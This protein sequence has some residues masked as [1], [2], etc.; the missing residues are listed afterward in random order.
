MKLGCLI[1]LS[2]VVLLTGC[3]ESNQSKTAKYISK[4]PA[5][6]TDILKSLPDEKLEH[7][8]L[9]YTYGKIGDDY[10][11]ALKTITALPNGFQM[12]YAT[13]GVE[14]EVN[15]GGFNQYFWNSTG[16]FQRQA[17]DGYKLIG[18]TA[19]S[20]LVAEAVQIQ[21]K[22]EA[23]MKKFKDADTTTAFSES[24]K[25]NP[26]NKCDSKFY[27]LTENA[28]ALRIKFIREHLELFVGS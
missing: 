5:L 9:D 23:K 13:T 7:A 19:H 11:N 2:L 17:I 16:Q 27:K 24:Y 28:S 18:A 26:L 4:Y 10:E 3:G 8:I 20:E 25:D 6:T 15:N 21:A 22:Q 14:M 12:V 1:I